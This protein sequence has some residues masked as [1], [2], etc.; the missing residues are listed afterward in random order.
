[1]HPE[2]G[3]SALNSMDVYIFG[4]C[5]YCAC[6]HI[7]VHKSSCNNSNNRW[8]HILLRAIHHKSRSHSNRYFSCFKYNINV[9][10]AP[11]LLSISA[12]SSILSRSCNALSRCMSNCVGWKKPVAVIR[13]KN[14]YARLNS[15]MEFLRRNWKRNRCTCGKKCIE[16]NEK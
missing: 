10:G 9:R 3:L 16:L 7:W 2:S 1:M 14:Q 15:N 11:L 8:L 12:F 6:C 5:A 13:E 4:E